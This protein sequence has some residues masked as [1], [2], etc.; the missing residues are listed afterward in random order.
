MI[1]SDCSRELVFAPA[2]RKPV[3][4]M[5][6]LVLFTGCRHV[7][8]VREAETA[9]DLEKSL[10]L[11]AGYLVRQ[12]QPNGQFVYRRHL[13]PDVVPRPAYNILRHAGTMYALAQH[14]AR[15]PDA[16]QLDALRRAA[17]FFRE[18]CL[19]P[20]EGHPEVLAAWSRAEL[21]RRTG[22]ATAKLGGAG[23]GLVGLISV[24]QV[25]PGTTPLEELRGLARFILAMQN[26]DGRFHSKF[27]PEAGGLDKEFV[28]LY[29]PGEAALGLVMLYEVDPDTRWLQSAAN[30]VG[31]LAR[32]R[33]GETQVPADHW[34]L[35][36]T[37]RLL[38]LH[39]RVLS[40]PPREALIA[41]GRQV[42]ESILAEQVT[43]APLAELIGGFALDGRTTPTATRLEGLLAALTFLPESDAELRRRIETAVRRGMTF[44]LRAQVRNGPHAGAIPRAVQIAGVQ[45]EIRS[46]EVRIDYV[47][48]AMSAMMQ[49]LDAFHP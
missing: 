8:P 26:A 47:Q 9:A 1:C 24:E 11:A 15:S 38:P 28:S 30:A 10:R 49:Y 4:R 22:P 43:N 48:H 7:S 36:A 37:A 46:G 17:R 32:L 20:V 45:N 6:T 18:Q 3:L 33:Q 21:T 27:T 25:A 29:Y 12:C 40:P 13:N 34:V 44:L 14:Q 31:Y 5:L 23:L 2:M 16:A 39:D 42:C 19:A 35:L 41:H